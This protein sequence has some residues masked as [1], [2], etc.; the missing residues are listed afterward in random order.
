M[1]V[2]FVLR[3]ALVGLIFQ[4]FLFGL[5]YL[6]TRYPNPPSPF[7]HTY[8]L[9]LAPFA[10]IIGGVT[11][12]LLGTSSKVQRQAFVRHFVGFVLPFIFA[13]CFGNWWLGKAPQ[14]IDQFT[15]TV[16]AAFFATCFFSVFLKLFFVNQR[17]K[18]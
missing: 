1:N 10:A 14:P 8:M 6:L 7:H 4:F 15:V 17:K 11:G 13:D 9:R 5:I 3:G 2:K 18:G 12:W 16:S